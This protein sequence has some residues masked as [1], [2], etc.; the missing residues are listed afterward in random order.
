MSS[1]RRIYRKIAKEHGISVKEVKAEMQAALNAA[2]QHSQDPVMAANQQHV[3]KKG[4][5]PTVEEFIRYASGQIRK[6]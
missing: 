6:S 3:P 1:M 4:E 2:Y 5:I